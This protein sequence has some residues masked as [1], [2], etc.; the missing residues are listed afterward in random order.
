M[1]APSARALIAWMSEI[2]SMSALPP[3]RAAICFGPAATTWAFLFKEKEYAHKMFDS[4][5]LL[6]R[7]GKPFAVVDD[8]G[9]SASMSDMK[10]ICLE[11]LDQTEA[12]RIQ[13]SLAEERVKIK[14]ME[15]AKTDPVISAAIRQARQGAPVITPMG[16]GFRG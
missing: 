11:D 14:A 12:A 6:H 16:G 7:D 4:A 3:T 15:A 2:V 10:G 5:L 8:F 9:Q 1:S 13:R